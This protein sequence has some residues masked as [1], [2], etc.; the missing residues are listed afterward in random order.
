MESQLQQQEYADTTRP[1][2][3]EVSQPGTIVTIPPSSQTD[4]KLQEVGSQVS[5]FLAKLP[6]IIGKF[7]ADYKDPIISLGLIFA[8][9]ITVKVVLAV[10]DALND[11]PLLAPTFELIGIAY[12]A[13][14][15]N[16]YLLKAS[17]RQELA[18]EIE[19]LKGQVVGSQ[20]VQ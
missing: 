5:E 20:Q 18:Q 16:R 7:W 4:K 17:N 8:A 11:I 10:I 6:N 15:V 1:E 14:F 3:I 12:S 13:W 19:K 2:N 9:I